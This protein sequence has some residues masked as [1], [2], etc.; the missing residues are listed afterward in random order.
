M[1]GASRWTGAALAAA[2]GLSLLA[3][4]PAAADGAA[5]TRNILFG[6]A[7]AAGGTL[8]IINHNKKVHQKYAQYDRQQAALEAQN[9]NS[10]AAYD[11]ERQAYEHEAQLVA[12]YKR[13]N[14]YQHKVVQQQG[15]QIAQL[16]HSL[17]LAKRAGGFGTGF[18]QPSQAALARNAHGAPQV[19]SYGWGNL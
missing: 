18:V 7:A 2:L 9:S 15:R 14:A 11:S 5:S 10:E 19:V 1:T 6:G 16:E 3:P 8:L 12:D 17:V 4:R 13:E